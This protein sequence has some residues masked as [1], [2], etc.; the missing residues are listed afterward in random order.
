MSV[1]LAF[2]LYKALVRCVARRRAA[3]T[4]R[5]AVKTIKCISLADLRIPAERCAI[6]LE[7][8]EEEE[9]EEELDCEHHY[10]ARCV[11][12]WVAGGSLHAPSA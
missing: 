7:D 4:Q 6:C 10:H 3:A 5:N 1:V 11:M 8:Y 2:L 9:E 12:R